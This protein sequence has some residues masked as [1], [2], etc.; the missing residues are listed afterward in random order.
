MDRP[1]RCFREAMRSRFIGSCQWVFFIVKY[2][3][4]YHVIVMSSSESLYFS[5]TRHTTLAILLLSG[6]ADGTC[7]LV[8][9][10]HT[11]GFVLLKHCKRAKSGGRRMKNK[12]QT[13][14]D[15]NFK[16]SIVRNV[17]ISKTCPA[18]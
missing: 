7:K 12:F 15:V 11:R 4:H 10:T 3:C 17:H 2:F 1:M 9:H 18:L 8:F 14:L 6:D 5:Q 16:D 13:S